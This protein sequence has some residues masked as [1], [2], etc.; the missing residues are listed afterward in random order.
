MSDV[1]FYRL[2]E[3]RLERALAMM[4]AMAAERGWRSL[5]RAPTPAL[6]ADLDARLWQGADTP[7]LPHGLATEPHAA[8]QP[9]LLT[10]DPD[11]N[12][13]AADALFLIDSMGVQ[14]KD[15]SSF[16]RVSVLFD[17]HDDAALA[18]A[19]SQWRTV[20]AAGLVAAFWAQEPGGRWVMKAR[21]GQG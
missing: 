8:R 18:T 1:R 2:T 20:S 13:N 16:T 11:G 3:T 15:L 5:V 4:L 19:R 9:V 10:T 12:P 6:I 21:S 7:F 14:P 17:G